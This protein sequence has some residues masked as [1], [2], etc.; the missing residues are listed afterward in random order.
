MVNE[1][2]SGPSLP[3]VMVETWLSGSSLR[4]RK[5]PP[6]SKERPSKCPERDDDNWTDAAA[7]AFPKR[8]WRVHMQAAITPVGP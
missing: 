2:P 5:V 4:L 7:I 8:P 6:R 3:T 1:A